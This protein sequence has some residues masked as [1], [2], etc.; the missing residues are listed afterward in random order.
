MSRPFLAAFLAAGIAGSLVSAPPAFAA[1]KS[2]GGSDSN[3]PV[4]AEVNGD[5]I[6]KSDAEA[7]LQQIPANR[8][9]ALTDPG[10]FDKVRN[11]LIARKLAY[12]EAIREGLQNSPEVKKAEAMFHQQVVTQMY[13]QKAQGPVP[14]DD[15]LRAA[16]D[17]AIKNAPPEEE[18]HLRDIEVKTEDEGKDII[19]QL[20]GGAD[21]EKL[22]KERSVNK[23]LAADGGDMKY[24]TKTA[25][26]PLG[27]TFTDAAFN[28][29]P[30]TYTKTPLKVGTDYHVIQ[31]LDRRTAKLPSFEEAKPQLI[32]Q[33][34]QVAV[35]EKLSV[36]ARGHVQAFNVDGSPI[37]GPASPPAAKATQ[38]LPAAPVPHPAEAPAVPGGAGLQLP[39]TETQQ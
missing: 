24:A 4:I 30:N 35:S 32:P 14:S 39:Q 7:L 33:L 25:L 23:A 29:A 11:D 36:L 34:Q 38:P 20:D 27:A 8:R 13:F 9:P 26:A 22:A 16:Y 5:A 6:H 17:Q 37:T 21:F 31:A 1:H 12:Q 2:H 18:V 15:K 3:D 19:K 10:I 28:L